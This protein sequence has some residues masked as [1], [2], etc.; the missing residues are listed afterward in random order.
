[1]SR[2]NASD[3]QLQLLGVTQNYLMETYKLPFGVIASL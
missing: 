2:A 3:D 1:L